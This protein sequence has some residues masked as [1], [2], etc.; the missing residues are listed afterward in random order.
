M[1]I[2]EDK[3][4]SE[5]E[6]HQWIGIMSI[7][8]EEAS[9][10]WGGLFGD[11]YKM[12]DSLS[13]DGKSYTSRIHMYGARGRLVRSADGDNT[14]IEMVSNYIVEM[15]DLLL[16]DI[17]RMSNRVS[18]TDI[19][20]STIT[21]L[22]CKRDLLVYP[23]DSINIDT[24]IRTISQEVMLSTVESDTT[25]VQLHYA[26]VLLAIT[27]FNICTHDVLRTIKEMASSTR[28]NHLIE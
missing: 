16:L 11:N 18:L 21:E 6:V 24:L 7:W 14:D 13:V 1:S 27:H 26:V 19:D 15:V 28:N 4:I 3:C 25:Y 9:K 12:D 5:K 10:R 22:L 20:V 17:T 2:K 8:I 23:D